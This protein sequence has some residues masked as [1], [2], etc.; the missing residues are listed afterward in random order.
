MKDKKEDIEPKN[1]KGQS[2]GYTER[3]NIHGRLSFRCIYKNDQ[4]IGYAEFHNYK[5]TI[6]FIR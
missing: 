1:S 3:Y 4:F 6:F 5:T 2:H